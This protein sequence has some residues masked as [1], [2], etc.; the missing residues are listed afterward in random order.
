MKR[1]WAVGSS[2]VRRDVQVVRNRKLSEGKRSIFSGFAQRF[3]PNT[4]NTGL[5]EGCKEM[6]VGMS[7]QYDFV[8]FFRAFDGLILSG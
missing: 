7:R 1:F 8:L 4:E 3:L 6:C 2:I 5:V